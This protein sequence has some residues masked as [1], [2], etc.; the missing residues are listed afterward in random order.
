MPADR[1]NK[2]SLRR[3]TLVK[4]LATSPVIILLV[5]VFW[6]TNV[7]VL[8]TSDDKAVFAALGF[9]AP[10]QELEYAAQIDVIK[11]VQSF[12]ID[13][14]PHRHGIPEHLPREPKDLVAAGVG[15]CFDRSRFIEKLLKF[16]GFE[17]RHVFVIFLDSGGLDGGD[18]VFRALTRRGTESHALTEVRT[19]RGWLLVGSN[20][21]WISLSRDGEP[22]GLKGLKKHF[23]D[24]SSSP[25][26]IKRPFAA[27]IG[28][29][30]RRGQLYPPFLIS[31]E[32]NYREVLSGFSESGEYTDE[33]QH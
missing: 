8:L 32:L 18:G 10:T 11:R 17:T 27:V 1:D 25:A 31:P 16:Q 33:S 14:F 13:R 29:Y 12:V 22:V 9:S 30:S 21:K 4:V 15:L 19:S 28:L 23:R 2:G 3:Q 24:E 20:H 6:A 26:W 5:L 7:P